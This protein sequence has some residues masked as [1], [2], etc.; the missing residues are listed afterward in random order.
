MSWNAI[1]SCEAWVDSY[2]CHTV[3]AA[4]LAAAAS[5]S[6][7]VA[8]SSASSGALSPIHSY[9]D[10]EFVILSPSQYTKEISFRDLM[11]CFMISIGVC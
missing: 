8:R 6:A 5:G 1:V 3:A 7:Q 11:K 2:P 4:Q 10:K 9:E